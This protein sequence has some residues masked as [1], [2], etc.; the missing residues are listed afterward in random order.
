MA[1]FDAYMRDVAGLAETTRRQRGLIVGTGTIR[2]AR[3]KT[4][5]T[6]CLPLPKM[7]G[8]AIADYLRHERPETVNRAIF[9]RDVAPYDCPVQAGVAKRAVIA[10]LRLCGWDRCDPH[11]LGHS[12]ASRLLREGTP[13]KHIADILRHRS[14]NLKDLYQDRS[15]PSFGCCSSLAREG[16]MVMQTTM[17]QHVVAYLAERSLLG[18]NVDGPDARQLR[19]FASFADEQ[20]SGTVTNELV[21]QGVKDWSRIANP[22]TC[23]GRLSVVKPFAAYMKCLVR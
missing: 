9:V 19:S 15:R 17:T 23:A 10:A 3:S 12:V 11:V 5:F 6:D 13:M 7:T 21:T 14:L 2:I 4:H 22:F 16:V 18:F 8:E 1:A 20:D